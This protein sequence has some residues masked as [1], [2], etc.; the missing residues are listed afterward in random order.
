[1]LRLQVIG[2][3]CVFL[4]VFSGAIYGVIKLTESENKKKNK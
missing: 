3:A 1:M 4:M 2:I